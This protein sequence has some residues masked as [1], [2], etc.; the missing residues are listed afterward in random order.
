M[1]SMIYGIEGNIRINRKGNY[2]N[3]FQRANG[4]VH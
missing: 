4:E 3:V 1:N 2:P